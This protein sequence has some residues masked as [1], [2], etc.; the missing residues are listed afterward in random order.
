MEL[1]FTADTTERVGLG[2]GSA[3]SG[4]GSIGGSAMLDAEMRDSE[5]CPDS[6]DFPRLISARTSVV[7]EASELND[8]WKLASKIVCVAV[9]K[10]LLGALAGV[11]SPIMKD[12]SCG[13]NIRGV[14]PSR[15]SGPAALRRGSGAVTRLVADRRKS[16][17]WPE[18]AWFK[19]PDTSG[20]VTSLAADRRKSFLW[21]ED[22][23]FKNP[24]TR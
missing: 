2:L 12:L 18:D 21:P 23:V 3:A 11:A 7:D 16:F 20:E 10:E 24:D 14:T 19:N 9:E 5:E 6:G 4:L 1:G 22:T 17:F 13:E 8:L 15:P